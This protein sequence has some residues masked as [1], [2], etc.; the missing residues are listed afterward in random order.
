MNFIQGGMLVKAQASVRHSVFIM[1][2]DGD[3]A[4]LA[5]VHA[6]RGSRSTAGSL[7]MTGVK[8]QGQSAAEGT[9]VR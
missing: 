9:P 2:S 7:V 1:L 6:H 5:T 3:E 8:R 4:T